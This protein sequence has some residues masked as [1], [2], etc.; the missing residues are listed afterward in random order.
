MPA[1]LGELF[2]LLEEE[3]G[4]DIWA[5]DAAQTS[6]VDFVEHILD[7]APDVGEDMSEPQRRAYVEGLVQELMDEV[8]GIT[9]YDEDATFA[10]ILRSA[11]RR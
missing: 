4:I 10:E 3:L 5:D 11:R 6:P 2:A 1:G 9:D 8:L 7:T